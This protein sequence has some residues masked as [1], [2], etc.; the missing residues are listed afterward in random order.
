MDSSI[1]DN[2]A[3][4]ELLVVGRKAT[5]SLARWPR[6]AIEDAAAPSDRRETLLAKFLDAAIAKPMSFYACADFFKVIRC[7]S[8]LVALR[9]KHTLADSAAKPV[10]DP[11]AHAFL[12]EM[13]R[14][15]G[16]EPQA[17]PASAVFR[18]TPAKNILLCGSSEKS[19][20]ECTWA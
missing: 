13:V 3:P 20:P 16:L 7:R 4:E 18:H 19:P 8:Q 12:K 17:V 15:L 5:A 1:L 10:D 2:F 9:L 11:S 14:S 6:Q